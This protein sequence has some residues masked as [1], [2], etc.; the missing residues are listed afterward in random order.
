M[1][2]CFQVKD[3]EIFR[4]GGDVRLRA[5]NTVKR[6]FLNV[7]NKTIIVVNNNL[8]RVYRYD[9]LRKSVTTSD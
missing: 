9:Q 1:K 6:I 7:S 8:Y 5:T 4:Q 2:Y 3:Y